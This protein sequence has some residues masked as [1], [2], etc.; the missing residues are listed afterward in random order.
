MPCTQIVF[1]WAYKRG[2]FCNKEHNQY[3]VL[4]LLGAHGPL[5]SPNETRQRPER[6]PQRQDPCSS[7]GRT[8][9]PEP[10]WER[11]LR[12][13]DA[14]KMMMMTTMTEQEWCVCKALI[15]FKRLLWYLFLHLGHRLIC[16]YTM[17]CV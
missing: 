17:C 2:S 8:P 13:R 14:W 12:T 10:S 1:T 9:V 5:V 4:L 3:V 7:R 11:T 16:K 6:T 15:I